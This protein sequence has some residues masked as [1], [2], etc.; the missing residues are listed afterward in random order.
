MPSFLAVEAVLEIPRHW[1]VAARLDGGVCVNTLGPGHGAG[2]LD[3]LA[4]PLASVPCTRVGRRGPCQG[5][6]P[7]DPRR[8]LSGSVLRLDNG[9]RPGRDRRH[10]SN[11]V[12]DARRALSAP[13]ATHL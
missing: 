8:P 13:A 5:P 9:G 3:G 2:G 7:P 4:R 11:S 6:A 10:D 12:V 1:G